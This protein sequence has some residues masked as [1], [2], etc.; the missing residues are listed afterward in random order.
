MIDL[1][2]LDRTMGGIYFLEGKFNEIYRRGL[3]D[4][5]M[6]S[7]GEIVEQGVSVAIR[8]VI[9]LREGL[10]SLIEMPKHSFRYEATDYG[11]HMHLAAIFPDF[12]L[13]G[14]FAEEMKLRQDERIRM[15]T[16]GPPFLAVSGNSGKSS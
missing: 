8:P 5:Y 3:R 1:N 13:A 16:C 12:Y 10:Y 11:S 2:E 9:Y 14:K 7:K 6:D 15:V 4:F